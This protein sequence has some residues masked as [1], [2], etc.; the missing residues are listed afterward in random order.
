MS[1]KVIKIMLRALNVQVAQKLEA[2]T[3]ILVYLW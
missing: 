2:Y 1:L 3:A